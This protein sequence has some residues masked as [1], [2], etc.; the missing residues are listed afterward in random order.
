MTQEPMITILTPTYNSA[1]LLFKLYLSLKQQSLMDFEWLIVDDGSTDKTS[2][3]VKT[4]S[5]DAFPIKY[6]SKENGGKHTALNF[7]HPYIRGKLVFI[8]DSDDT[9]TRDAIET[10]SAYFWQYESKKEIACWSFLR[11][12]LPDQNRSY[13]DNG[14]FVSDYITYRINKHITGDC[15]EI[16][17]ADVFVKYNFPVIPGEKFMLESWLWNKMAKDGYKTA[18]INKAIYIYEYLEDGLTRKARRLRM[19]NPQGAMIDA[20]QIL[21]NHDVCISVKFK[22]MILFWI[23]GFAAS[24]NA[25]DIMNNSGRKTEMLFVLPVGYLMY[26]IWKKR[27]LTGER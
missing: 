13:I 6:I 1:H 3:I 11:S 9:L 26:R 10:V 16:V 18:Y 7:S 25:I 17:R 4:F 22:Y 15:A 2:A 12:R 19:L 20:R 14:S 24:E 21:V 8:V 23:Y 27:Y 5:N